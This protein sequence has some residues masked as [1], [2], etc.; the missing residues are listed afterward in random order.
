MDPPG[1]E[2]A[3]APKTRGRQ[4]R[5]PRPHPYADE[6]STA[7]EL[8]LSPGQV[9]LF[10]GGLATLLAVGGMLLARR[11]STVL[12]SDPSPQWELWTEVALFGGLGLLGF[13]V[14]AR[15]WAR[16]LTMAGWL[17]FGFYWSLVAQDLFVEENGDYVNMAFALV[18]TYFFTYLAYHQWLNEVRQVENR[19]VRFLNVSTFVAAG[20]YFIIDKLEPL[21]TWLIVTV[22]NQTAGMLGLFGQGASKG[23][24]YLVDTADPE[25]PTTFFYTSHFCD[26]AHP[27]RS[28]AD[29]CREHDLSRHV[30]PVVPDGFW[31]PILHFNPT[32]ES[33][34]IIPVT[35][36]LACT[37]LQSIMLFVG[38]FMGTSAPWRK[39][40]WASALIA[41]VVYL[42]NLL[43]N[44]G[45]IWF[46]GQGVM[47][48]WTIHDAIGKGGSLLA[49]IGIAFACFAWFPEFLTALVGVLDLPHR[50]GPVE[51]VLRLGRRR[52][53]ALPTVPPPPPPAPPA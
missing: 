45:I 8:R 6:V 37:A 50:D 25:N 11:F 5:A 20:S 13:G 51:R 42:L 43:R 33:A 12:G 19:T 49:M 2:P 34:A 47:S 46:Y 39:K 29:Y 26:P 44:T 30:I 7:R 1:A 23:L 32:H 10:W 40:I 53:E 35:V 21:R 4:K 24:V 27:I 31:G 15:P 41:A 16:R 17:L 48:F 28:V 3:P 14:V 18:G 52:P 9:T 22:S 38:L 36:I